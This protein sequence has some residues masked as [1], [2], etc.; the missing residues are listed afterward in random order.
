MSYQ[1]GHIPSPR[2]TLSEMTDFMEVNCLT[3][4][5]GSFSTVE[6]STAMGIP[7]DDGYIPED[8]SEN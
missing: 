1:L 3:N 2:P 4:D 7:G 5:S 8:D 6:V